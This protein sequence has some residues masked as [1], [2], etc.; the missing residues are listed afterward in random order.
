VYVRWNVN[1][2][3]HGEDG[4]SSRDSSCVSTGWSPLSA[5]YVM[6]REY[7]ILKRP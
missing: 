7:V 5:G 3:E 4:R 6:L 1:D 2:S